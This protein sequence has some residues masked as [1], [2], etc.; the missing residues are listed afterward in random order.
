M[1]GQ[2]ITAHGTNSVPSFSSSRTN[3]PLLT[4]ILNSPTHLLTLYG[5]FCL[6]NL[7]AKPI[8]IFT[9]DEVLYLNMAHAM[10]NYGVFYIGDASEIEGA[11]AITMLLTSASA[12]GAR[13]YPQ[14]PGGYALIAA[15][16]YF[17]FGPKGLILMNMLSGGACLILVYRLAEKFTGETAIARDALLLFGLATFFLNYAN[18][19]W[20]HMTALACLLAGVYVGVLAF[21][22]EHTER[23]TRML[24]LA[25]FL[26]GFSLYFRLDSIFVIT[27]IFLWIRFFASPQKRMAAIALLAGVLPHLVV[28]ATINFAKYGVFQPFTYGPKGDG[29]TFDAYLPIAIAG[30]AMIAISFLLNVRRPWASRAIQVFHQH[31][32]S[33]LSVLVA[34]AILILSLVNPR[35]LRGLY[36]LTI[37]LQA[38]GHTPIFSSIT[39]EIHNQKSTFGEIKKALFQSLPF[40]A[41]LLIPIVDFFRGVNTR[42]YA[43]SLMIIAAPITF[44][45]LKHWHGGY[46]LNM[47]YFLPC[48]PFIAILCAIALRRIMDAAK[49]SNSLLFLITVSGVLTLAIAKPALLHFFPSYWVKIGVYPQFFL[50]VSLTALVVWCIGMPENRMRAQV[51]LLLAAFTIGVSVYGNFSDYS[52]ANLISQIKGAADRAHRDAIAPGSLVI[53]SSEDGFALTRAAGVHVMRAQSRH[54]FNRDQ[55]HRAALAFARDGRCVYVHTEIAKQRFGEP[56]GIALVPSP[57]SDFDEGEGFMIYTLESQQTTCSLS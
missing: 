22:D 57:I 54:L 26:L 10:A 45:G 50:F 13:T 33:Y 46:S 18:G 55:L 53:S 37:D 20:P 25:G 6:F 8:G 36:A 31:R 56:A 9:I 44:Y 17:V 38:Y 16:F 5:I 2:S 48:V 30:T 49:A 52:R 21:E 43:L 35:A 40:A 29:D 7:V 12:E 27:A 34:S 42:F 24:L 47:R 28:G 11:P 32:W 1:A 41:L 51:A 15:P 4:E 23:R 14:Y 39:D 19:I 3:F